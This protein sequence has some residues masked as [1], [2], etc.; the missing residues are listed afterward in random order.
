MKNISLSSPSSSSFNPDTNSSIVYLESSDSN[1]ENVAKFQNVENFQNVDSMYLELDPKNMVIGK[2]PSKESMIVLCDSG[3][4]HTLICANTIRNSSYLSSL[5]KRPTKSARFQVGNGEYITT[6]HA[7]DVTVSIQGHKF[8][9]TALVVNTLAGLSMVLGNTSL[10]EL[11]ASLDFRTNRLRFK[12]KSVLLKPTGNFIIQPHQSRSI[13]LKGKLPNFLK[14]ANILVSSLNFLEKLS[15]KFMLVQFRNSC[16]NIV[17]KNPFDKEIT[18]ND[19]RPVAVIDF[20]SMVNMYKAI[21]HFEASEE[22]T[23]MHCYHAYQQ[24]SDN[25][26]AVTS[27]EAQQEETMDREKLMK[28]KQ[29]K[30]P[31]LE[32]SDERLKMFDSEIIER[33]IKFDNCLLNMDGRKKVKSLLLKYKD[34]MSLH[35]EVGQTEMTV[36]FKLND[37]SPFY[38]RPFTVS[39]AEKPIIDKELGK[40]VKMGILEEAHFQYSSP[41]ILQLKLFIAGISAKTTAPTSFKLSQCLL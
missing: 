18:I 4:S 13:T 12:S 28:I 37:S 30:F 10:S 34:A 9:V 31:F 39:A 32:E 35:S 11:D 38:I 25:A 27:K 36:D 21:S 7:I 6:N 20:K 23:V 22:K 8:L 29:A 19:S 41:V 16:T 26:S 3:A 15:P 14:N 5:P 33:D 1:S 17:V 24:R 40:L 2:L